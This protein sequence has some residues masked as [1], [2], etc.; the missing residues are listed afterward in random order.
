M[1]TPPACPKIQPI[2]FLFGIAKQVIY[3]KNWKANDRAHLVRR[4]KEKMQKMD[5]SPIIK[6]FD[7]LK[8]KNHRAD[9][10]GLRSLRKVPNTGCPV[11]WYSL[12][13]S[14]PDFS[15]CPIKKI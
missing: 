6:I 11:N 3:D 5:I 7:H 12:S 1:I 2:E 14:I 13:I 8:E 4:I 15:D 9:N 10:F